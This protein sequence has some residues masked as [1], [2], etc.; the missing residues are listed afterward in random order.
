MDTCPLVTDKGTSPRPG[1][2]RSPRP[3]GRAAVGGRTGRAAAGSVTEGTSCSAMP[4]SCCQLSLPAREGAATKVIS[5]EGSRLRPCSHTYVRFARFTSPPR[6]S[7]C[8]SVRPVPP[9]TR[10]DEPS[11]SRS[12]TLHRPPGRRVVDER[13]AIPYDRRPET[14]LTMHGPTV[15]RPICV[16]HEER[17]APGHSRR[18]AGSSHSRA[19]LLVR[20][21][22]RLGRH[23]SP[24]GSTAKSSSALPVGSTLPVGSRVSRTA[25]VICSWSA[26]PLKPFSRMLGNIATGSS[27]RRATR[28]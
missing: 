28:T 19:A 14:T 8:A 3:A 16:G 25:A 26:S 21:M 13:E 4:T 5:Q 2:P 12:G 7:P 23:T 6:M 17:D 11:A 27:W 22:R 24:P 18:V 1:E 9:D 20:A 15:R 10:R